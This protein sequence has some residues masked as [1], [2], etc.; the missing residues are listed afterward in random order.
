MWFD[1]VEGM[2][3]WFWGIV[4]IMSIIFMLLAKTLLA[5][6]FSSGLALLSLLALFS[7]FRIGPDDFKF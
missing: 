4:F 2:P 5:A 1:E 7:Y 3:I 6:I